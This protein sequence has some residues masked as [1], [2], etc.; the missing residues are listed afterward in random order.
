MYDFSITVDQKYIGRVM[1]DMDRLGAGCRLEDSGQP[2]MALLKGRGPVSTLSE[3]QMDLNAFSEGSG[4]FMALPGGYGPCHDQ[5]EVVL[6]A[7]YDPDSDIYNPCGSV[8]T[9]HG[10][11]VYV[12]WD[13]VEELAHTEGGL[14]GS[15]ENVNEA[16]AAVPEASVRTPGKASDNDEKTLKAIF[17]KTYGVS[18]RDEQLLKDFFAA[19]M[20]VKVVRRTDKKVELKITN[21]SSITYLVTTGRN[22]IRLLP[23]HSFTCSVSASSSDVALK[24]MNMYCSRENHPVVNLKF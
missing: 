20:Q 14:R 11:G 24:V 6:A 12:E 15:R 2:D 7:G 3:Y 4:R 16:W 21:M 5:D 22:P 19:S 8:F 9:D 23:F 13:K 18:K 17:E 10:A 1:T